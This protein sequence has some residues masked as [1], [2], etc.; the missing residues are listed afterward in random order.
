MAPDDRNRE[1]ASAQIPLGE[2]GTAESKPIPRATYRLQFNREFGFDQAA[3]LAPYL[4]GLGVS[5]VYC[6][7]YLKA[8]P[9]SAHGYDIIS[10]SE[11][12]PDL[13]DRDSFDR[14]VDAFRRNGLRQVL[15][16]VPNHMGVGGADNP[17]WL[18]V[19]EWG[20]DSAFAGW[21]DIDWEPDQR[22]LAGKLLVPILG[23]QFGVA[24]ASGALK[25][26]F[27][28]ETGAFSIW[29][30]E[31]HRLPIHPPHYGRI[32][33]DGHPELE[34]LGD[35]FSHLPVR[36][37]HVASRARDMRTT[38]AATVDASHEVADALREALGRFTGAPG[39]LESWAELDALIRD[40][41]WRVAYFRVASDDINYRRFFDV[42]E[43]ACIRME[44]PELFDHAHEL[45]FRL[46]DEGVVDGLRIDHIDGLRNP[47]QYC[48]RLRQQAPRPLY[49]AVEK[50]LARHEEIREDWDVDGTTGYE[51]ASLISGLL[52]DPS[53]QDRLTSFYRDFTGNRENFADIVRRGKIRIMENE[54][55]GELNSLAHEAAGIARSNPRTADFT[56]NVLYRA[57]K[58]IIAV[59][60]VYRTYIDDEATPT[61]A[62]RRDCDWALAKA[63][64]QDS[65]IDA[66][67]FDFLHGL[68]T[69]DLVAESK[70]GFSRASVIRWATRIQQ[71]TGPVMAKGLEDTAFYQ[72]NR[73]LALNEVGGHPAESH[74]SVSSFHH[75][76][77]RRAQRFPH[78]M[79]STSTH[80]SKRGEDAR[81]R[82]LVLSERADEWVRCVTQWSRIL[83]AGSAGSPEE[84]PPDRNDE[85][86]FYQM[87]LGSWPPDIAINNADPVRVDLFRLR[88]EGAMTKAMREAKIHTTWSAPNAVYEDA[89]LAFIRSALDMTRKNA[90]LESFAAFQ[91]ETA[92]AGM[93]NSLIQTV[94][95][96]T[97]PGVPD[98]YQ[99]S[100]L[101][102][103]NFVDPDN[104]R[105][106]DYERRK[107]LLR[108]IRQDSGRGMWDHLGAQ[109]NEWSDG[110]V[111]LRL[112]FDLLRLR[113]RQ[114]SLFQE[115]SYEPLSASGAAVDRICAFA[116]RT[117]SATLVVAILLYPGRNF[118]QDIATAMVALPSETSAKIWIDLI[119]QREITARGDLI[120]AADL[121][122][123]APLAVL[124]SQET[125]AH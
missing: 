15:D 35:A 44:L 65:A 59:F 24:L 62:D 63:R 18:D 118:F 71:Y 34:R 32:L 75:A 105:A 98:F 3:A 49:V 20:R 86:A 69:C 19:L 11:L 64:R 14:M 92:K 52:L 74:V 113:K 104:R 99:G 97:L 110:S 87:L 83:R 79:L 45:I 88:L 48:L 22:H 54:L 106:V 36:D 78:S 6:S 107:Q 91:D 80:D 101:W 37:L 30:Y 4:A 27:D 31:R 38:L 47:K 76:N 57:L 102:D 124:V 60:P 70:S 53:G 109:P 115:G 5:H 108:D 77:Q 112:I 2:A 111:K 68:L 16:F 29:A 1:G 73:M 51:V 12:N 84:T 58:E 41:H 120:A 121:F 46:I 13:G 85:Y 43:L 26:E 40:Q 9:G 82:M 7:P 114:S 94:L 39:D 122:A 125:R 72:Y 116:R 66:S 103:L 119:S 25:L 50:I 17:W 89:A 61:A 33:R 93:Y 95:K 90:F 21:F 117:K 100:E 96:L 23:E 123:P 8:R 81:A 67:V 10:H 55:A 42:N 28:S 56:Q